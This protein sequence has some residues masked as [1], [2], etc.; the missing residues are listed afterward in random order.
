MGK[1]RRGRE[2]KCCN[3]HTS[4]CLTA[5]VCF[6]GGLGRRFVKGEGGVDEGTHT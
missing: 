3:D 2:F 5:E 4:A 1:R 6:K